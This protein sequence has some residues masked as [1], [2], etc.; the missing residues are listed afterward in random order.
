[1][2][3]RGEGGGG[4]GGGWALLRYQSDGR[5]K[6]KLLERIINLAMWRS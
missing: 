3:E 5:I 2:G 6:K 4:G 1:M